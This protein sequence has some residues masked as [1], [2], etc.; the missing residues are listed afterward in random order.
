MKRI[1]RHHCAKCN[2]EDKLMYTYPIS[3]ERPWDGA[4][5]CPKCRKEALDEMLSRLGVSDND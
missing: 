2:K 1:D 3:A 5:L 4:L